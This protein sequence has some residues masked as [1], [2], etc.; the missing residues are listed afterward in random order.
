MPITLI[1]DHT[2][3]EYYS[4][5]AYVLV[6]AYAQGCV[7]SAQWKLLFPATSAKFKGRPK[8]GPKTKK[9]P[10]CPR[11]KYTSGPCDTPLPLSGPNSVMLGWQVCPETR[12]MYTKEC[13]H[14]S[15]DYGAPFKY[16]LY[17]AYCS[18]M[19][20]GMGLDFLI[21]WTGRFIVVLLYK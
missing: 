2:E 9:Y 15:C 17:R 8:L 7:T 10:L 19:L 18:G 20:M 4:S 11:F 12:C 13:D 16:A 5:I 21:R 14:D 3:C 6:Y 1:C